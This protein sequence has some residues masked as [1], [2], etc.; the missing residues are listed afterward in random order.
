MLSPVRTY[1]YSMGFVVEDSC[2]VF[3][4][5]KTAL[6]FALLRWALSWAC[7]VRDMIDRW[8]DHPTT[9]HP[10]PSSPCSQMIKDVLGV[11][12]YN[13]VTERLPRVSDSCAICLGRLTGSDQV[14]ELRNCCHVYHRDCIDRWVDHHDDESDVNHRSCPLCRAPLLGSSASQWVESESEPSWTVERIL[15]LFGDDLPL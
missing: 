3:M 10:L 6:A 7:R 5:Y 9:L 2:V 11:T 1:Y 4:L 12:T 8:Y 15:Y 14:R 13:D